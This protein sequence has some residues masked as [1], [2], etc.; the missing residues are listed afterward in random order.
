MKRFLAKAFCTNVKWVLAEQ[1]LRVSPVSDCRGGSVTTL[2]QTSVSSSG[3]SDL[4]MIDGG[5]PP[6]MTDYFN[7]ELSSKIACCSL[8]KVHLYIL[9]CED[10]NQVFAVGRQRARRRRLSLWLNSYIISALEDDDSKY[11]HCLVVECVSNSCFSWCF[12]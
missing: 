1:A 10:R 2:W 4:V 11:I 9:C 12:S 8:S 6:I 3:I 5:N 7:C